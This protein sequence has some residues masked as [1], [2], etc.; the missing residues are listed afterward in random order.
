LESVGSDDVTLSGAGL[1]H[2]KHHTQTYSVITDH[3][4]SH[5]SH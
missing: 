3:R 2:K 1:Q 5:T 4:S